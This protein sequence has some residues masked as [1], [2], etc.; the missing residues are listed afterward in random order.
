MLG[1]QYSGCCGTG[2]LV[3][4]LAR[5]CAGWLRSSGYPYFA[6]AESL[7]SLVKA[8]DG[9]EMFRVKPRMTGAAWNDGGGVHAG[10]GDWWEESGVRGVGATLVVAHD[11]KNGS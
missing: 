11:P 8:L 9:R 5:V 7:F 4:M 2:I 3:A 1:K 6:G 10:F